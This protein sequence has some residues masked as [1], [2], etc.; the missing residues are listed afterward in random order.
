MEQGDSPN[1]VE[2][3]G[4]VPLHAAAFENWVEGIE[5]LL[6]LGAKVREEEKDAAARSASHF[7]NDGLGNR[8]EPQ[9]SCLNACSH[10][11]TRTSQLTGC[12]SLR[13]GLIGVQKVHP[14]LATTQE[15]LMLKHPTRTSWHWTHTFAKDEMDGCCPTHRSIPAMQGYHTVHGP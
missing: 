14:F 9:D 13:E 4:N 2:A 7:H 11:T 3:A 5:L 6:Q 8:S 15:I 10:Y 12:A 1:E